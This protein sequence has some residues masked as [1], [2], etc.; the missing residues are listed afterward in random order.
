MVLGNV[1]AVVAGT[2]MVIPAASFHRPAT[3]QAVAE[4]RCTAVYSGPF[5]V[6]RRRNRFPDSRSFVSTHFERGIMAG[7]P[8]PIEVM[9]KVVEQMHCREITIAYLV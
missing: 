7:S 1:T 6:H 5:H 9:K 4:E 8:C 2:C 3:L